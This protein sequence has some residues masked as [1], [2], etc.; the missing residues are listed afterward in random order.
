MQGNFIICLVLFPRKAPFSSINRMKIFDFELLWQMHSR[1]WWPFSAELSEAELST[2]EIQSVIHSLFCR[3]ENTVTTME[4]S[5]ASKTPGWLCQRVMDSSM[6][7]SPWVF[8]TSR[9]AHIYSFFLVFIFKMFYLSDFSMSVMC[10]GLDKISSRELKS[11][12]I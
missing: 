5:E 6:W 7:E 1:S 3:A 4:A 11:T 2:C 10:W 12:F 9:L 8:L